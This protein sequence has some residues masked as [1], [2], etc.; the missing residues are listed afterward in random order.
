MFIT[1][2]EDFMGGPI[3]GIEDAYGGSYLCI[4]GFNR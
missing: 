3:G 1:S 2:K 4:G